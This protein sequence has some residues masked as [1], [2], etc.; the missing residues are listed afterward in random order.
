MKKITK[1]TSI[2]KDNEWEPFGEGIKRKILCYDEKLMMVRVKF[3]KGAG[4]PSHHHPH[5][6]CSMIESGIFELIIGKERKI[7]RAGDGF[8]IPS[9]VEHKATAME[10]GIIV[11][12][13]H[14]ARE[15][16]IV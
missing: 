16:F 15:D 2:D 10:E 11:D 1:T 5:L 8:F 4:V 12:T 6:Q 13:F 3:E 7:L 9:G 14:P